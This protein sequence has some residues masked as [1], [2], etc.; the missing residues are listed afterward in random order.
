[1]L[2]NKKGELS[3]IA[4]LSL[5]FSSVLIV[6]AI[7]LNSTDNSSFNVT[8]NDTF[9]NI[10]IPNES[11]NLNQSIENITTINESMQ[12]NESL[13]LTIPID[14]VTIPN[15]PIVINETKNLTLPIENVL[16]SDT[17]LNLPINDTLINQTNITI[18]NQ[19]INLSEISINTTLSNLTNNSIVIENRSSNFTG[20]ILTLA[21]VFNEDNLD[22]DREFRLRYLNE[23]KNFSYIDF[24]RLTGRDEVV[25]SVGAKN[26]NIKGFNVNNKNF[27]IDLLGCNSYERYCIFRINGIPT[28]KL[29]SIKDFRNT[30]KNSFDLDE[31]YIIKINSIEFDFCDNKRFCHLGYEGY[32]IVNVSIERK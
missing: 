26:D 31:L 2:K 25:F 21:K 9:L 6:S 24:K 18:T 17:T 30:R 5:L 1:M 16:P 19:S 23:H 10:S 14:N 32:H 4:L 3:F 27:V 28:K 8:L 12:I 13:N 20:N 11:I 15:Q 7:V 22:F 29:H